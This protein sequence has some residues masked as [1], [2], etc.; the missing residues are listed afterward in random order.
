MQKYL[1][2]I[3]NG[4]SE[5]KCVVYDTDGREIAA[6]GERL[7]MIIP[8]PDISERNLMSVWKA[9]VKAIK[10]AIEK[11]GISAKDIAGIGLTGYGNGICFVDG[12]G[13]AT[14]NGIVST[15]NRAAGIVSRFKKDGIE[16]KIFERTYQNIWSAQPAALLP[17]FKEN[18]PEVLK[19]SR[20]AFGIKDYIRFKLTGNFCTEITEA[21]SGCLYNLKTRQF[22]QEIF[23]ILDIKEYFDLMPPCAG[24]TDIAGYV[25]REAASVTG[26]KEG[27]P[28]AAGYF[29]I[30][31]GALGSGVM[32]E[33]MLSLIAG[34]WSINEYITKDI[35]KNY[36]KVINTATI[37]NKEG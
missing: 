31:A 4:G 36:D 11:S 27:T 6:A 17:W 15:D 35:C 22:D 3:D 8:S 5:I 21:S 25:T 32:N 16:R 20:Y 7:P 1:L 19:N 18:K 26:L 33:D 10:D 14:E 2:G 37:S 29:D 24:S 12:D 13:N 34:T 28:V 30:D 23:D 9:N